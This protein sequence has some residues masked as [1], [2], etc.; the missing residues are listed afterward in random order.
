MGQWG[1]VG[2]R[3]WSPPRDVSK[4]RLETFADGVFAIAAT[5]LIIRV[6]ADARGVELGHAL[7]HA[8]PQYAAYALSFSMIGTWWVNHHHFMDVIDHIDRTLLFENLGMLF[9]I[10][11]LPFPTHLVAEHFHDAGLRAAVILYCLTQT[12][13]ATFGMLWWRHA[14]VQQLVSEGTSERVLARHTRDIRAG[15][16]FCAT[17]ALIALWSPVASLSIIA[18][19]QLFYIVGG[20]AFERRPV[21][22]AAGVGG[23]PRPAP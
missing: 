12:G 15:V 21:R 20:A 16:P 19:A 11:F 2:D 9:F 8:W 3:K 13:A 17:G 18:A 14:R 10:A 1:D 4:G 5:L 23:P 22:L 6:S 7:L